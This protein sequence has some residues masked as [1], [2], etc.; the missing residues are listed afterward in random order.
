MSNEE[1]DEMLDS[2]RD[3]GSKVTEMFSE[4]RAGVMSILDDNAS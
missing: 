3:A 4:G 1:I 2:S